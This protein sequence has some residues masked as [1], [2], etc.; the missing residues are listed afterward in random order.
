MT[1]EGLARL[2]EL[3]SIETLVL[4]NTPI[5]D[6][7][8]VHLAGMPELRGLW[9]GATKTSRKGLA[10]LA[11]CKKLEYL[12]MA[13]ISPNLQSEVVA[14]VRFLDLTG[15][16][17]TD[18]DLRHLHGL[19]RLKILDIFDT[20]V[21]SEAVAELQEAL[22][23]CEIVRDFDVLWGDVPTGN[24][25]DPFPI[26][27]APFTAKK[28]KWHQQRWADHLG[29]PVEF[30]NSIGMRMVLIPP[31]EFMMGS[32]E[33]EIVAFKSEAMSELPKWLNERLEGEMPRHV[34]PIGAPYYF[35]ETEL[36][37]GAFERFVKATGYVTNAEENGKGGGAWDP[38]KGDWDNNPSWS[39]QAPGFAQDNKYPVVHLTHGDMEAFCRWLSG[40]EDLQ[41]HLPSEAEWEYA[42]RA[43]TTSLYFFGDSIEPLIEYA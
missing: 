12:E 40:E 32:S 15:A 28:A 34:H 10:S 35:A 9:L 1:N 2:A 20:D 43:G 27:F 8:L 29:I 38:G 21:T 19:D 31:G 42:C 3:K 14:N 13:Q 37:V 41:Y 22:P 26:A 18:D 11:G 36:T 33:K 5:S 24:P 30:E 25:A 4:W 7:G 17:I 6:E 39:W 16:R 23:E